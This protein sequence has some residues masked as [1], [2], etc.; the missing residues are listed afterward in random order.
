MEKAYACVIILKH[1]AGDGKTKNTTHQVARCKDMENLLEHV[2]IVLLFFFD[3]H[4]FS[5]FVIFAIQFLCYSF[6]DS[7]G[8]LLDLFGDYLGTLFSI[9]LYKP[10]VEVQ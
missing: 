9:F 3:C 1:V 2:W 7:F 5:C 10:P 4:V 8:T 6:R